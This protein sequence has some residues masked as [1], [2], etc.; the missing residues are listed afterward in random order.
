MP[1]II[2]NVAPE[3]PDVVGLPEDLV[4][5]MRPSDM[6]VVVPLTEDM[7]VVPK[8]AD[9]AIGVRPNDLVVVATDIGPPGAQGAPGPAGGATSTVV[10]HAVIQP[11]GGQRIVRALAGGVDYA[12]SDDVADA[13]AIVGF[14][15]SA[16]ILDALVVV[17][18]AGEL[19][20]GSWNWTVGQPIFCGLNGLPTQVPP[21]TGFLCRVGKATA[22]TTILIDVDESIILA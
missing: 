16:A 8:V 18:T 19:T 3:D 6:A 11:L 15:Q 17:Q 4:I 9:L 7:V 22:P 1:D 13:N 20:E 21:A 14:T 5:T 2:V 12:S 10:S